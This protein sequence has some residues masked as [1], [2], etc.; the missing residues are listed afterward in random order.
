MWRLVSLWYEKYFSHEEVVV[1]LLLLVAAALTVAFLGNVL[2]PLFV[3][4][5]IAY[6]LDGMVSAVRSWGAPRILSVI[7]VYI[8]FLGILLSAI[9]ILL[10]LTWG[11]LATFVNEQLPRLVLEVRQLIQV[12]PER[13]PELVTVEQSDLWIARFQESLTH[14][15][16]WILSAS[17]SKLP[18]VMAIL[19]FLVLVPVLVFFLM[20]DKEVLVNKISGWLPDD[21]EMLSQVW[22]EMNQQFSNYIRG[23]FIEI[24]IVGSVTYIALMILGVNYAL[25]LGFLVGLSVLIPFI[26]AAVATLP[27][28]LVGYFQFGFTS[29]WV[30]LMV[31]YAVIQGLDGNVLVPLLFSEAVNLHPVS[32]IVAVLVFGGVWGLWGV[33]F[34][35]PLATLIKAVLTAWSNQVRR[36]QDDDLGVGA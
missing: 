25:L 9:F 32:I 1:L 6:L 33:F 36:R 2:A 4:V 21:R 24:W 15:G 22:D 5:F 23:K 10:P 14:Y 31:V 27:V 35:I 19:I 20:K 29:E 12:L 16:E 3:A 30:T 28:A 18:N 8:A 7:A 11:Q 26:G 34:A 17:V 13:F